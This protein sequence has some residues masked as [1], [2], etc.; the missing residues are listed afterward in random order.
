M[1]TSNLFTYSEFQNLLDKNQYLITVAELQGLL[2]GFYAAGL[3]LDDQ[4]WKQHLLKQLSKSEP[5]PPVLSEQLDKLN[6]DIRQ[7]IIGNL[8]GLELLIPEDDSTTVARGEALGYWCQG[9][10][11]GYMQLTENKE[12]IEED[13]ADALDDLE[14]ISN[15]DLDSI[16]SS[17]ED[18]KML[19]EI[20][21]HI[22]VAALLIHSVYG[23][24]PPSANGTVH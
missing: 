20:A 14:E 16:G 13:L 8:I 3:S 2:M 23:Q 9:F 15:I 6:N 4:S 12:E 19:F 7:M 17:E 10:L 22:K 21:E 1:N 24:S 5:V 11:L 18:E